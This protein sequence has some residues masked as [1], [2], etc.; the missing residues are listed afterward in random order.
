MQNTILVVGPGTP[1][2][3]VKASSR[4]RAESSGRSG[5]EESI[6]S[7]SNDDEGDGPQDEEIVVESNEDHGM[8]EDDGMEEDDDDEEEEGEDDDE[9][10]SSELY[11]YMHFGSSEDTDDSASSDDESAARGSNSANSRK[12]FSPSIRHGGCINTAAWLTSDCGWR[13]STRNGDDSGVSAIETEELPTQVATSGD[14][15]LLKI[16]DVSEAMGSVSPLAGGTATFTPFSS[17]RAKDNLYQAREQWQAMYDSRRSKRDEI[18]GEYR[19]PGTVRLLATVSTGHRG[20]VF[21]VTPLK[22]RKGTFATC[23]A[24]GFLRLVDVERASSGCGGT[25]NNS[26]DNSSAAVIHPMYDHNSDGNPNIFDPE[27]PLAFFLRNSS[28]MCFSHTMLDDANVGLLCSEKGLLRFDFRLSPR[29][30]STRSLLPRTVMS[31]GSRV[32]SLLA[33]KACTVLRTDSSVGTENSTGGGSTY[34]FAG[35][36]SPS[37]ALCDLRMTATSSSQRSRSSR[38][39]QYYK[40][41]SLSEENH[42]SVSGLDLSRDGKE[43]LVSY[44]SDQIYTFP[45]FPYSQSPRR[46]ATDQLEELL[47]KDSGMEQDDEEE[48]LYPWGQGKRVLP[49]LAAYGAHLNRFTFL[50]NARYAGPRDEYICT[51][52]DS[53]HA[54]VYEKA[55]GAVVSFWKADQSTCN[56]V[57]PHPTLPIFVTYGI[58]STAKLWRATTPVDSE[59]DDSAIGR[60]KH[61]RL[62]QERHYKMTPTVRNWGEVKSILANLDLR[63]A[64]GCSVEP[65]IYPDQIPCSKVLLHRGRLARTWFRESSGSSGG[66]LGIPKI[67]NDL[68]NLPDALKGNLYTVLRSLFDDDDVPVESDIDD[69]KQRISLIR[70][71]HQADCLGLTWN[72][73]MP[74]IMDYQSSVDN[75]TEAS[76]LVPEHPSDWIPHDAYMSTDPFDFKDYFCSES[77]G[78][79]NDFYRDRY[80][81]LD[82]RSIVLPECGKGDSGCA[83]TGDTLVSE[84]NVNVTMEEQSDEDGEKKSEDARDNG[85]NIDE[86]GY[87]G[88]KDEAK[89]DEKQSDCKNDFA[90][91]SNQILAETVKI[92][93]D[94]GNAAFKAGKLG[95][96]AY[97]YD[98]AIQYGSVAYMSNRKSN[99]LRFDGLLKNLIMTRLNM[100]LVML[101]SHFME[102]QV[103]TKQA[104]LALQ[105][106][107]PFC[108]P[109]ISENQDT[110]DEA[111]ALKAKA[112]FRLG[113]VQ[114]EMGDYSDSIHSLEESIKC[115]NEIS[116]PRENSA[117]SVVLRRLAQAKK[118]QL[119]QV[120]RQRKKFKFAFTAPSSQSPSNGESEREKL[121]SSESETVLSSPRPITSAGS[122]MTSGVTVATMTHSSPTRN[123]VTNVTP[124]NSPALEMQT[125]MVPNE[126]SRKAPSLP[127]ESDENNA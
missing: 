1:A 53:G 100:A 21:H 45:V 38:V 44:E 59:V 39:L 78:L 127:T 55:T 96:A 49:E 47:S 117:D 85:V 13:L 41:V 77:N 31:S 93:K 73:T 52:S 102:L 88:E 10:T 27:N 104:Q 11:R 4:K 2:S 34:V 58:D 112:C 97:R 40:P 71:R 32:R 28:G 90:H 24:D 82:E 81:A 92:L 120:K 46:A 124:M 99:L 87:D 84:Q 111:L 26:G 8:D 123:T 63:E 119:K 48:R 101:N 105:E 6:S 22:G 25:R 15:R 125:D 80:Y 3:S 20:N 126:G 116:N 60:R 76:E 110:L 106:V 33:C 5:D 19:P 17:Y 30:Q 89:V 114:Y 37:V 65:D 69:F 83:T 118:E 62:T 18:V 74:W 113:S 70:L 9:G 12:N 91:H 75:E 36:S 35:G 86:G 54:W 94:G 43:L 108:D 64:G 122:T 16:W 67:G 72:P 51:G 56:G 121:P 7:S 115:T 79:Y 103:A 66:R 23:G 68:Q 29:E 107:S 95:L 61:F 109:K 14:D 57:V 98:K 50:K 42:V